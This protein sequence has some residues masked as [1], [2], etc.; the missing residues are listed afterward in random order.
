[1]GS[2]KAEELVYVHS[3]LHI[4]SH[5]KDEYKLNP[6]KLCNVEPKLVDLDITLRVV[7]YLNFF[8]EEAPTIASSSGHGN[9]VPNSREDEHHDVELR[10]RGKDIFDDK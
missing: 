5:K 9:N 6:N 2:K 1:L 3:N 4:L 8:D 7:S 10:Y